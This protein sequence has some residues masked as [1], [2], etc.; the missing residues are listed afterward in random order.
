MTEDMV[1]CEVVGRSSV[2]LV[3]DLSLDLGGVSLK[4]SGRESSLPRQA[5]TVNFIGCLSPVA[6]G[7]EHLPPSL[8]DLYGAWRVV[9]LE[10]IAKSGEYQPPNS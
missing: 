1:D 10:R 5:E 6:G 9:R 2:E 3:A 7:V 4:Y 8:P